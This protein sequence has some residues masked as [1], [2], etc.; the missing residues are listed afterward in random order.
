MGTDTLRRAG[1][2]W[3]IVN[4]LLAVL[5]PRRAVALEAKLQNCGLENVGDLEPRPWLV[6]ATRA[7]GVGLIATGV[8][9]LVL[10]G[11]TAEESDDDDD[12]PEIVDDVTVED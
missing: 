7:V 1:Y 5:S 10:E 6:R 9:G 4:G 11:R 12:E 2:A 3:L 8:T